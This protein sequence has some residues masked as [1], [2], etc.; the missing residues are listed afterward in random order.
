MSND[1]LSERV[2][3]MP[4]MSMGMLEGL[5]DEVLEVLQPGMLTDP[6][7]LDVMTLIDE[8]PMHGIDVYP[9]DPREIGAREGVTMAGDGRRTTILICR[10]AWHQLVDGGR[11]AHRARA[12]FAHELGHAIL[13]GREL[14]RLERGRETGAIT[15]NRVRRR[16][17][18]PFEDPEWQAWA[19]A[20]CILAPRRAIQMVKARNMVALT[21]TFEISTD[22]VRSH[23][24]RLRMQLPYSS[25]G[26][27]AA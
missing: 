12:T 17:L 21:L 2:I 25:F 26:S 6:G 11:I 3:A 24:R 1:L 23:L 5:A 18:R 20:G 15:L 7:A 14:R 19:F 10:E 27:F 4:P 13:H 16:E 9:V 8:L 22:M